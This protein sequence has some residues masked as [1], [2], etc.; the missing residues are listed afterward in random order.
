MGSVGV[1]VGTDFSFGYPAGVGMGYGGMGYG[2]MG[3]G[4]MYM[5]GMMGMGGLM[6]GPMSALY[7][8]QHFIAM[9]AQLGGMMGVGSQALLQLARAAAQGASR[10]ERVV[11]ESELRRWVQRKCRR[12]ALLRVLLVV[13]SMAAAAQAVR[14][15][16]HLIERHWPWAGAGIGMG[17]LISDRA[18]AGASALTSASIA[19]AGVGSGSAAAVG[20]QATSAMGALAASPSTATLLS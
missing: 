16:R 1:G 9:M 2:G 10:L 12:S 13:C 19:G 8:A 17:G 18:G 7:S 15:V 5:P 3:Y 14:L 20:T 6:A 11:R 4:G